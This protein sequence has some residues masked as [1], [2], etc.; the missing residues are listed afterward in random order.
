M[1]SPNR[2][3]KSLSDFTPVLIETPLVLT[4]THKRCTI[5]GLYILFI[6]LQIIIIRLSLRE[7]SFHS[8]EKS[9][10]AA[11]G[12]VAAIEKDL[13]DESRNITGKDRPEQRNTT[14]ESRA[15]RLHCLPTQ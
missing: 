5:I 6:F 13:H 4:V 12:S 9:E 11:V 14:L 3:E 1:L 2:L 10:S 15:A 7:K 8:D